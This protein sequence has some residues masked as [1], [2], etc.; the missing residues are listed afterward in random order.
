MCSEIDARTRENPESA[1][2]HHCHQNQ[3]AMAPFYQQ[4]LGDP[5]PWTAYEIRGTELLDVQ[6]REMHKA[7]APSSEAPKPEAQH[8][9]TEAHRAFMRGLG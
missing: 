6:M 4:A 1:M 5:W 7:R 2:F 8:F 9:D 3:Q